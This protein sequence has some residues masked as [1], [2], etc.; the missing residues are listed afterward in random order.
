MGESQVIFNNREIAII[1][2]SVIVL[3]LALPTKSAREFLKTS[4]PILFCKKF[5][6]FY[7]VFISFLLFVLYG[8]NWLGFWNKT[9]LKDTIFWVFFVELP[10]FV[11][12]V[13]EADGKR[14]F[15]KLIKKNIT[16]SVAVEFFVKS[17]SF[18]LITEFILV[19]LTATISAM[20]TLS[21]QNKEYCIVKR[22]FD[23]LMISFGMILLFYAAYSLIYTPNQ[24]FSSYT[25]KSF[26]L[27]LVLLI[28][29]LPV[30]YCLALY[31]TYEEV[32]VRMM[33]PESEK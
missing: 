30:V 19:P 5:V 3:I 2:W 21:R 17:W 23:G 32:F 14:F 10:I 16:V 25:L 20:H 6:A 1:I 28:L 7:I 12:A 15:S 31:S 4:I 13:Q 9:L 33:V 24:F 29:N 8:L 22:F 18:G 26:L 27:P 11:K